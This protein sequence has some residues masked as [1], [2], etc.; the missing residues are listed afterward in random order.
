MALCTQLDVEQKLQWDVTADPDT[1]V[2]ALI[3]DAQA[4]IESEIG[5]TVE[6]AARTETFD[7]G[8]IAVYLRFWP[9]TAVASVTEDGTALTAGTEYMFYESGKLIRVGSNGYQV[10]F[11]TSKKQSIVVSY[12]GGFL[13]GHDAEH[14]MA[15]EDLGSLCAEIV[16][17]AFRKGADSAA[18]PAGVSG[19]VQS[20]SLTGSDT[21]TYATAGGAG[22]FRG[23]LTQF[24]YLEDNE[25]LR[26]GRYKGLLVG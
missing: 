16:A 1:T 24:V 20:V 7:G 6:S 9:V 8:R 2:A 3:A 23:G 18:L 19:H 13:P 17:R 26:L 11:K 25:R 10:P 22:T 14:D 4:L 5:R 21:V 15:L 12:T